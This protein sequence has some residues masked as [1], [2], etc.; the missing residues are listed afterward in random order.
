MLTVRRVLQLALVC[1]AHLLLL[2][3][4][5]SVLNSHNKH[6]FVVIEHAGHCVE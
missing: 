3:M 1:A 5:G 4:L 6:T 2:S